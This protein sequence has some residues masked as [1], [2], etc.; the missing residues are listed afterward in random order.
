MSTDVIPQTGNQPLYGT[1]GVHMTTGLVSVKNSTP[2]VMN[3]GLPQAASTGQC[4]GSRHVPLTSLISAFIFPPFPIP[5][6]AW[7]QMIAQSNHLVP[8]I[9]ACT[10]PAMSGSGTYNKQLHKPNWTHLVE[11]YPVEKRQSSHCCLNRKFSALK[12]SIN[13][14]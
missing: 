2:Q 14:Y 7:N 9:A 6:P 11:I 8:C 10:A 3:M 5:S 13:N 4:T 12:C 1:V